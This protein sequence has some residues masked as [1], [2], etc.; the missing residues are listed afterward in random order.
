MLKNTQADSNDMEAV[1]RTLHI[2]A[3]HESFAQALSTPQ[4]LTPILALVTAHTSL[5]FVANTAY[6]NRYFVVSSLF[7]LTIDMVYE[8]NM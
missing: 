4:L 7:E 5:A 2:L 6:P 3:A 8:I 1:L